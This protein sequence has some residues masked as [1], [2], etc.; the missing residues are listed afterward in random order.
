V[1]R[2]V[3]LLAAGLA[4]AGSAGYLTSQAVGGS[5]QQPTRTVTIDVGTGAQGL[6]GEPGPPG[7][8]GPKGDP[9]LPGAESCPAG[10]SFGA[11]VINAPGGHVQIATCIK[12]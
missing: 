5:T 2:T 6:P 4:L 3:L 9:G 11:L 8:P 12:D 10:Y 7:P 1:N